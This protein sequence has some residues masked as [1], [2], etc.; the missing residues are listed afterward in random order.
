MKKISAI[1]LLAC[2]LSA[3]YYDEGPIVSLRTQKARV[4]NKWKYSDVTLNGL[5]ITSKFS[6]GYLEFKK[7]GDATFWIRTDSVNYGSWKLS[8][9]NK[10]LEIDMINSA[11]DSTWNEDYTILK[12]KETEMWLTGDINGITVRMELKKY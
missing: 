5:N 8:D 10:T 6:T 4:V 9:D 3:C 11:A 2:L 12:L 7:S 1:A